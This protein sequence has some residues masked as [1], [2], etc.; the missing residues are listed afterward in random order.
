VGS[1]QT[2][3][4]G[5]RRIVASWAADCAE[6]VLWLF[7][8][9]APEDRRPRE[10]IA[11]T[12]A[13]ARGE[14]DV[15]EEIRRRFVGGGAAR[16]VR[17]PA[18]AAAARAAGQAAAVAHMG[19][20]ALGA[21]AYAAKAAALA[22]PDQHVAVAREIHWQLG[23]MSA[24]VKAALRLL[25]PIGDDPSGPLGPGLLAAGLQGTIIRHLQAGLTDRDP[26]SR[27]A[28]GAGV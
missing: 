24:P 11:R 1:P 25:P 3:S 18:A 13:F 27:P 28:S 4:E 8:A 22:A 16:E 23:H 10:A 14:L 6:R 19:A 9:Q 20:H 21:A 7:E 15:A 2:L 17:D 5:D 12:R 26:M